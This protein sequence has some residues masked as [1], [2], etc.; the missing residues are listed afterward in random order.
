MEKITVKPSTGRALRF[1][2]ELIGEAETTH[3]TAPPNYSG[4]TGRWQEYRLYRTGGNYV[5]AIRHGPLWQGEQDTVEA[6]ILKSQEAVFEFFGPGR[7][8]LEL[9]AA[10]GLDYVTEVE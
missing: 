3:Q 9:Y 4:E 8:A 10:A 6:E 2:G 5:G 7:L 1:N